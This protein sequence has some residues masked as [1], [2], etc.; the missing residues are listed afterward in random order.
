[1]AS[2]FSDA[3]SRIRRNKKVVRGTPT[4]P[5]PPVGTVYFKAN[6]ESGNIDADW[7]YVADE[8]HGT[9]DPNYNHGRAY[10]ITSPAA[11]GSF[12][13]RFELD[14]DTTKRQRVDMVTPNY[15][16]ALGQEYYY[17][18]EFRVPSGWTQPA[19]DYVIGQY[20]GQQPGV[21]GG[22][23]PAIVQ[24]GS[25]F[26]RFVIQTGLSAQNGTPPFNNG[27]SPSGGVPITYL[28][29]IGSMNVDTWHQTILR[30][31]IATNS[32]GI[33]QGWWRRRGEATWNEQF[34]VTGIPTLQFTSSSTPLTCRDFLN[35]YR[36]QS[37]ITSTIY[38]DNF[39]RSSTFA[40]AESC[41]T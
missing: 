35:A 22:G 41:F 17:S 3:A 1:M 28:V 37:S 25:N 36:A 38:H 34:N 13:T 11:S 7:L 2:K 32:T 4:P 31:R 30:V 14:A 5:A 21:G 23:P 27:G 39:G 40:A 18:Q 12:A 33:F 10:L 8:F 9:V 20:V 16:V 19:S 26:V 6:F 24:I 15:T 29:P